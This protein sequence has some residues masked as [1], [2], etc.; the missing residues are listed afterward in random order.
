[1][2]AFCRLCRALPPGMVNGVVTGEDQSGDG[3]E[4]VALLQ[5]GLQNGRQGLRRVFGGIVEQ[6]DG[7]G[8]HFGSDPFGDF[9]GGEVLP[10]QAVHTGIT[11]QTLRRKGFRKWVFPVC[12]FP[13]NVPRMNIHCYIRYIQTVLTT[14]FS[15]VL[16]CSD[17][18]ML[19]LRECYKN[20]LGLDK[21]KIVR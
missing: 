19:M 17:I 6:D 16:L 18:E 14:R 10:V 8:L 2:P 9:S 13:L 20:G 3:E 5:K 12:G 11:V 21:E 15:T 7:T 4:G 1:M